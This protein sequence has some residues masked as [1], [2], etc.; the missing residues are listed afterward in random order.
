L[1]AGLEY[2]CERSDASVTLDAD[3]QDDIRVLDDMIAAYRCGAELVLGV[4]RS[5]HS[6]GVLKRLT[7]AAYYRLLLQLGV[8]AVDQHADFRL[9][10][11]AAMRNLRRFP[12]R[13]LFLRGLPRLLHNRIAVVKYDRKERKAGIS[14]YPFVRMT[15]LAWD[16]VTSFSIL[17]LRLVGAI[18]AVVFVVSAALTVYAL[19]GA[20]SGNVVPGWASITVPLYL[21]GGLT[22]LSIGI[23]GEYVGK[24]VNEVKGRPR[25]LIDAFSGD[26]D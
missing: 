6:D 16:G 20:L 4:R 9:M 24:L 12:E 13:Q 14:K 5:R 18:G 1:V 17:P 11:R 19:L 8:Q 10:S 26:D 3:L 15:A 25:Y 2:A 7:A 22:M 21:L 23:L